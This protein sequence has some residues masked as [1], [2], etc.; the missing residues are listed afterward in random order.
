LGSFN[1]AEQ[2]ARAYDAAARRIRGASANLNFPDEEGDVA[3]AA[4]AGEGAEGGGGAAAAGDAAAEE[5]DA[6]DVLPELGQWGS[7]M[8]VDQP[9]DEQQAAAE[10]D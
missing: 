6:A 7:A 4:A 5:Q 2:A 9:E 3:A 10:D 8:D 1:T